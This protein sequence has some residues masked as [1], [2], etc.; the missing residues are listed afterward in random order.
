MVAGPMSYGGPPIAVEGIATG[1]VDCID[2]DGGGDLATGA[3]AG[4]VGR[5]GFCFLDGISN[6]GTSRIKP[7]MTGSVP[8]KRAPKM[9]IIAAMPRSPEFVLSSSTLCVG[10][11]K[12][13]VLRYQFHVSV[14]RARPDIYG[15]MTV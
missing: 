15:E 1:W 2:C 14:A 3:F 11:L 5:P 7:K 6:A 9:I 4:F 12:E 10:R 13:L 8:P